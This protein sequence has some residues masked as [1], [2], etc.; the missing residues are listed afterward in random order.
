MEILAGHYL[1]ATDI[2]SMVVVLHWRKGVLI[3]LEHKIILECVAVNN[4]LV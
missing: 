1:P 4:I 3:S 2:T